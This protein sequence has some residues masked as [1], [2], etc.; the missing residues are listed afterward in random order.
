MTTTSSTASR[1]DAAP[2]VEQTLERS[3]TT[4]PPESGRTDGETGLGVA[5]PER[6]LDC[7]AVGVRV[8]DCVTLKVLVP[9]PESEPEAEPLALRELEDELDTD[10]E[11]V[12]EHEPLRVMEGEELPDGEPV[13]APLS[14]Y[15]GELDAVSLRLA[16]IARVLLTEAKKLAIT[17]GAGESETLLES[18][19]ER[20]AVGER[21]AIV[22]V[23]GTDGELDGEALGAH[24]SKLMPR[25]NTG[26]PSS[27]REGGCPP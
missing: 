3:S 21:A 16:V 10:A 26:S 24:G 25:E 14:E 15:A 17:E 1:S 18:V 7:A 23:T 6:V 13:R 12:P 5:V 11:P 22:A 19:A 27:R 8:P 2:P 9:V 4:R 20:D